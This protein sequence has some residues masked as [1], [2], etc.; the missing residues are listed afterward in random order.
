MI[1][2]Q[3]QSKDDDLK[4]LK[5]FFEEK[6]NKEEKLI[7]F[8]FSKKLYLKKEFKELYK[9]DETPNNFIISLFK[10]GEN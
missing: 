2:E 10:G 8:D 4:V 7:K 1:Y 3:F 6:D 5:D 9:E